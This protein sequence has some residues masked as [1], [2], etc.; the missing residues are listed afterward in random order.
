MK[1]DKMGL[2]GSNGNVDWGG[3]VWAAP[4]AGNTG[5]DAYLGWEID[6]ILGY[7]YSKD[8]RAQ[9]VYG[10]FIPGTAYENADVHRVAEEVRAELNVKF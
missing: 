2:A 8:V 7:D 10:A 9:L 3:P 1:A 5:N 6:G 4:V